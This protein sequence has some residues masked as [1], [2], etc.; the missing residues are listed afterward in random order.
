ML[1]WTLTGV[2]SKS[3]PVAPDQQPLCGLNG[4]LDGDMENP[5]VSRIM[6]PLVESV[7]TPTGLCSRGIMLWPLPQAECDS[8]PIVWQRCLIQ[9]GNMAS[10][11]PAPAPSAATSHGGAF[12]TAS[13]RKP[14]TA[15]RKSRGDSTALTQSGL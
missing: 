3:K 5:S 1:I 11:A 12:Q 9:I 2:D 6:P 15:I 7:C 14:Q 13:S 8:F 10:I 4:I